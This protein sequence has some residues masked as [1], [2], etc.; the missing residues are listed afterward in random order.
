MWKSGRGSPSKEEE[1]T[2]RESRDCRNMVGTGIIELALASEG[3]T[4]L[5]VSVGSWSLFE[6]E[7]E[8]ER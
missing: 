7:S 5:L 3:E 8:R 4:V 6:S 1:R 2:E